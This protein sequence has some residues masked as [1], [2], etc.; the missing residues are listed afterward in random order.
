MP[1]ELNSK[2]SDDFLDMGT[3]MMNRKVG[4]VNL[5]Y[6]EK[7][8]EHN[9]GEDNSYVGEWSFETNRPHGKGIIMS[10]YGELVVKTRV[11]GDI[12]DAGKY[13]NVYWS[14]KIVVGE[15]TRDADRKMRGLW[16]NYN[17]DG[18]Q[19]QFER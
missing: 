19:E 5:K 3:H 16:I 4:A 2:V 8:D 15:R 14:G 9:C 18:T 10:K 7:N 11:D 1:V 12:A 13:I 17:V 6:S